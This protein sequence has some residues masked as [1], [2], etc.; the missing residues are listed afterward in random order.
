MGMEAWRNTENNKM[1]WYDDEVYLSI[2][3]NVFIDKKDI[4]GCCLCF[5]K[6]LCREIN[7]KQGEN[8]N[9][10]SWGRKRWQRRDDHACKGG[11]SVSVTM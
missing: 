5:V 2:F 10:K 6:F 9:N 3:I 4:Q 1:I 7:E 8:N 11:T